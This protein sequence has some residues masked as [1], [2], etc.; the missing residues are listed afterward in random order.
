M[1][2]F[3]PLNIGGTTIP[4]RI[5]VPAMVTRLS[6]EDGFVNQ[7]IT[8]RYVRY[9]QGG[10]GLIVIE[11]MAVHDAKSGPLLRISGDQFIPGLAGL[12]QRI[13]GPSPWPEPGNWVRL[14]H[15]VLPPTTDYRLPA[16]A[17]WLRSFE[18]LCTLNA[19]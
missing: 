9:A 14:A 8:D 12:V 3:E 7:D 6:G 19:P 16:T 13:P 18:G 4:N 17:V 11:A 1:K 10:A 15:S 5:M 2:L